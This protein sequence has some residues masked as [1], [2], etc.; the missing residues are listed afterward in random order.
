MPLNT[1]YTLNLEEQQ[2]ANIFLYAHGSE[3][4]KHTGFNT[5]V[6]Q[7]KKTNVFNN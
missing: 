1:E 5:S 3:Y 6:T 2:N 4:N 7:F